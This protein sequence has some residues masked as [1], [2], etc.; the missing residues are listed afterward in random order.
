MGGGEESKSGEATLREADIWF[1]SRERGERGRDVQKLLSLWLT[2]PG[3][4]LGV[5]DEWKLVQEYWTVEMPG[6]KIKI[7]SD[8][9][10]ERLRGVTRSWA[11]FLFFVSENCEYTESHL[12]ILLTAYNM[13]FFTPVFEITGTF[14]TKCAD[15]PLW[16]TYIPS[17]WR[18]TNKSAL[19]VINLGKRC[20]WHKSEVLIWSGFPLTSTQTAWFWSKACKLEE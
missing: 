5:L 2:V 11:F 17:M 13:V 12:F 9:T 1:S 10:Q 7:K 20:L 3:Q 19:T 4:D 15:S 6:I 14:L 16:P 8:E 18:Q